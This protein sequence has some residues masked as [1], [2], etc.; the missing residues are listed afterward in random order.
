MCKK[1]V[2]VLLHCGFYNIL[3]HS[4][5]SNNTFWSQFRCT[6]NYA[7]WF[8]EVVSIYFQAQTLRNNEFVLNVLLD[9]LDSIQVGCCPMLD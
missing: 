7:I 5:F 6:W 8:G 9:V 2:I 1:L 3:M 4:H